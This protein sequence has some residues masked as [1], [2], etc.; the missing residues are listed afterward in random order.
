MQER[1]SY[2]FEMPSLS[3]QNPHTH[4]HTESCPYIYEM[5]ER[6][7][8]G[9]CVC[10]F[11]S[12][13]PLFS[14]GYIVYTHSQS[15][16]ILTS[17]KQRQSQLIGKFLK[18]VKTGVCQ[19]LN[20]IVIIFV[21]KR[22]KSILV[23]LT[24][25]RVYRVHTVVKY[26]KKCRKMEKSCKSLAKSVKIQLLLREYMQYF[27]SFRIIGARNLLMNILCWR[28]TTQL[29]SLFQLHFQMLLTVK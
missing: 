16:L 29:Y 19:T 15:V 3:L 28:H 13:W 27:S 14:S 24:Y 20:E 4:T 5:N 6:N 8:M 18:H 2:A 26:R 17:Q 7:G 23:C 10:E 22:C 11:L 12:S 21:R 25:E 1:I 9:T